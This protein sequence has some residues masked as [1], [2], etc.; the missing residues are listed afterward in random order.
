MGLDTRRMAE[1]MEAA[2]LRKRQIATSGSPELENQEARDNN[3]W[4]FSETAYVVKWIIIGSLFLIAISWFVIGY[5]HAKRRIQKGL[6]PLAYHRWL[7]P[8][9]QLPGYRPR[10]TPPYN[11]QYGL[12]QYPEPPPVY[13][14]DMPPVYQPPPGASK[15]DPEQGVTARAENTPVTRPAPAR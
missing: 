10:Y 13:D 2:M 8:K 7:V 6:K 1:M 15:V 14:P 3:D 5:Y 4:W 12:Q 11:P 9:S